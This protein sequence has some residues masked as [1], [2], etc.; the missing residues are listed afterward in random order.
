[1]TDYTKLIERLGERYGVPDLS[2]DHLLRRR[3][4]KRRNQRMAA[5]VVGI[6]VFVAAVWIVTSGLS[7]D[8][9]ETPATPGGAETGREMTDIVPPVSAVGPVPETDYLLDLKTGEMTPL[10]KTI[11]GTQDLTGDYAASP[12]G[13]RLAYAGP[14]DNGDRQVFVANLD[15]T[16][17]EQVTSEGR[18]TNPTWSPD[19][20]KI[21]YIGALGDDTDNVFVLDLA[22]GSS[23]QLTHYTWPIH[24]SSGPSFTPDGASLLYGVYDEST[25]TGH[26]ETWIVPT[27]GGDS[28]SLGPGRGDF[29][30]SPDGSLMAYACEGDICLAN[31]DGSDARSL[32]LGLPDV[33]GDPRWSPDGTR[34]AYW[35]F[36][37]AGEPP[38]GAA[39]VLDVATLEETNVAEGVR[40]VWLDD[41]TLIVE[42]DRCPGPRSDGCGG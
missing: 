2:T 9:S 20:S 19:G 39:F 13:S 23:T 34:I 17:V 28:V 7:F 1:M 22:T 30:F 40:P 11:V 29:A 31:A 36:H 37:G 4:R 21:A 24:V 6:A 27:L 15:E 3:D 26:R 32:G 18:A 10:P 41:H 33:V 8:R 38:G 25:N 35:E 14:D 5:G 12:D 16:G 42:H